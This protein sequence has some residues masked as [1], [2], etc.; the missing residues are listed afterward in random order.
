MGRFWDED[1]QQIRVAVGRG[2]SGRF[3]GAYTPSLAANSRFGSESSSF[4]IRGFTQETNTSP[5]VA[6]YFADVIA[7][8]VQGATISGNGAGPGASFDL[9]NVQVLKGPQGTLFGRNTTGGAILLELEIAF[10]EQLRSEVSAQAATV[11]TEAQAF[12]G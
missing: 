6:V 4:A 9:Q 10:I 11:P 2:G 7:P 8:R 3:V 1:F 5:S 12:V